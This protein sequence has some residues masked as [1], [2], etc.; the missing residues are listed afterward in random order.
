[1]RIK[2]YMRYC[3]F[4][5]VVLLLILIRNS[6]QSAL[7]QL[8]TFG[9]VCEDTP[10][11]TQIPTA[12]PTSPPGQPTYTPAPTSPPIPTNTPCPLT[13]TPTPPPGQGGQPTETPTRAPTPPRSGTAET[14]LVFL[15]LAGLL[16]FSGSL[17]LTSIGAKSGRRK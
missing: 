8:P 2:L 17:G 15:G 16:L 4:V 1:M 12:I 14:T 6:H 5:F 10:V 3:L 13:H 11:P 7:A 9:P